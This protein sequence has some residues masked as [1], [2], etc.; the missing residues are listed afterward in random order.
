MVITAALFLLAPTG[1]AGATEPSGSGVIPPDTPTAHHF[2]GI[3]TV[4]PLFPPGSL[5][6]TC[7]ASVVSSAAGDLL[8]TSAHCITGAADGYTF[9]P[10]YHEG[11]EPFGTWTVTGVY[12][13]PGWITRGEPQRDFSF[14]VVAP[15]I[16]HG[17]AE[18]IQEVTGGNRLGAAP[19]TGKEVTVPAYAAGQDDDPL[20]CTTRVYYRG[21][22]PA[23]NCNPYVDGTSGAPWLERS[24]RG[25]LVVGVIGGLHQGGCYAWTSYSAAFGPVTFRTYSSAESDAKPSVLPRP[26]S[27][28]CTTGL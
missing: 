1:W 15:R 8:L 7:T 20:T 25:W 9:A 14:L 21:E 24:G 19:T 18:Q 22:Y 17:R 3:K 11:V 10:G 13:A 4:G 2:V 16:E 23:F 5:A 26:A 28:G 12:G 27:D 6:H